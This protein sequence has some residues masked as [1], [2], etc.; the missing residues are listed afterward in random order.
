MVSD[1]DTYDRT[2]EC[3]VTV[4]EEQQEAICTHGTRENMSP[5]AYKRFTVFTVESGWRKK[6]EHFSINCLI[7]GKVIRMHKL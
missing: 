6:I 2:A 7:K 3:Y 5:N 4:G 1:L